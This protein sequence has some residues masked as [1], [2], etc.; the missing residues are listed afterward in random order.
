MCLNKETTLSAVMEIMLEKLDAGGTVTFT[1][2]GTSMLPMLRDGKDVVKLAK[3]QGR[4]N[5]FD[6]PLYK[7][8]SGQYVLHRVIDFSND[9]SYVLCGDNQFVKESGITDDQ[10]IA[11]LVE[12]SR[13]GKHY[14]VKSFSYRVYVKY[15]YHSRP[16]RLAIRAL[17]R[18]LGIEDKK[19]KKKNKK[20]EYDE[21]SYDY[22]DDYSDDYVDDYDED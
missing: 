21:Y 1:P 12:F 15:W 6:V 20:Y 3:P 7:R 4:L 14:T 18:R 19:K 17:K 16:F 9:G 8:D 11:V 10:I 2:N 22:N 5:L 13:K